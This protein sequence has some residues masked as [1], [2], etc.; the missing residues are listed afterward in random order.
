MSR[1]YLN[2]HG[3]EEAEAKLYSEAEFP[4]EEEGWRE[5]EE[6]VGRVVYVLGAGEAG[7]G[8]VV[9]S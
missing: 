7:H 3:L 8:L 1:F 4:E 6:E 5:G 2:L 9:C